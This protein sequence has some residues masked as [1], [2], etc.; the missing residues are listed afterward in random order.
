[1]VNN[2]LVSFCFP[3]SQSFQVSSA[4]THEPYAILNQLLISGKE[5]KI[6]LPSV[7][8]TKPVCVM[9]VEK[10]VIVLRC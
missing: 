9:L 2:F 4:I 10:H 7:A 5:K 8:S 1:M 3:A 6:L